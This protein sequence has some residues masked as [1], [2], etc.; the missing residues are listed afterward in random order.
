MPGRRRGGGGAVGPDPD[1]AVWP[2]HTA[3]AMLRPAHPPPPRPPPPPPRPLA[4]VAA[5]ALSLAMTL[6][7]PPAAAAVP[8]PPPPSVD[9]GDTALSI[10]FKASTDPAIRAAQTALVEAW[11]YVTTLYLD[12]DAVVGDAWKAALKTALDA[13]FTANSPEGARVAADAMLA[14]LGD[15]YTRL[16]RPGA[17]ADAYAAGA[18]G[19]GSSLGIQLVA[20]AEVGAPPRVAAVVPASPAA[21]ARVRVGDALLSVDGRPA[22]GRPVEDLA[23]ALSRSA[24]IEVRAVENGSLPRTLKLEAAD[25]ALHAVQFAFLPPFDA[26]GA[27]VAYVRIAAFNRLAP[28]DVAAAL[29]TLFRPSRALPPPALLLDLRDNP[30]GAVDAGVD[31]VAALLGKAG[32]PFGSVVGGAFA[33]EP[34]VVSPGA[35]IVPPTTRIAVLVNHGTASTAEIVAGALRGADGAATLVGERTFGKGRTQRAVPLSDGSLLLVSNLRYLA[36]DGTAV[37]GVGLS[38]SKACAPDETA[39]SF[40][41]AGGGGDDNLAELL[42]DDPCV[43]LAAAE[44]GAPLKEPAAAAER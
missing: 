31:V 3:S 14:R 30:G 28:G 41:V 27:P 42:L 39:A 29:K 32:G 8:P 35:G 23:R 15:P 20:A 13:S 10:N 34:V 38:P 33:P 21:A 37:D 16:L 7:P 9:A 22:A 12:H 26:A 5:A 1:V 11:G 17:D 25:V 44:L 24:T 4:A 19:E 43:R 6:A 18:Q 36:P 40:F 2:G